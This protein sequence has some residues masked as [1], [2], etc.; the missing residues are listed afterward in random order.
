MCVL[1]TGSKPKKARKKETQPRRPY[2]PRGTKQALLEELRSLGIER[3]T[4]NSAQLTARLARAKEA[5]AKA[6]TS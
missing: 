3:L 4:G 2:K 1:V 6:A 5:A